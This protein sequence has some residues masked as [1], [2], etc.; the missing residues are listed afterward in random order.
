MYFGLAERRNSYCLGTSNNAHH[1]TGARNRFVNPRY[2]WPSLNLNNCTIRLTVMAQFILTDK[3]M[4]VKW[5]FCSTLQLPTITHLHLL[6]TPAWAVRKP[7]RAANQKIIRCLSCINRIIHYGRTDQRSASPLRSPSSQQHTRRH[8]RGRPAPPDTPTA[9]LPGR[10]LTRRL[11]PRHERQQRPRGTPV[12]GT[13]SPGQPRSPLQAA[14]CPFPRREGLAGGTP[15]PRARRHQQSPRRPNPLPLPRTGPAAPRPAWGDGAGPPH[16]GWR[17]MAT[18]RAAP[19]LPLCCRRDGRP[20]RGAGRASASPSGRRAL[21]RSCARS[22]GAPAPPGGRRPQAPRCPSGRASPAGLRADPVLSACP[23]SELFSGSRF[24]PHPAPPR[25][26][27]NTVN[28]SGRLPPLRP[29]PESPRPSAKRE[30][31]RGSRRAPI[32]QPRPRSCGCMCCHPPPQASHLHKLLASEV[33]GAVVQ[34]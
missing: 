32:P 13:A 28:P 11:C 10:Q 9:T 33:D 21:A 6:H 31:D 34:F 24:S 2:F 4:S 17:R 3:G 12:S 1:Q 20:E 14:S 30:T 18:G 8:L 29:S 23:K 27:T 15:Q 5:C 26:G 25:T 16:A 19:P 7:G 22:W